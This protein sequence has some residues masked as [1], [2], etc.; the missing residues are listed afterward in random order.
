MSYPKNA[1]MSYSKNGWMNYPKNSLI[2]SQSVSPVRSHFV[3]T[4]SRLRSL[5]SV[6]VQRTAAPAPLQYWTLAALS[7][8]APFSAPKPAVSSAEKL[9]YSSDSLSS[10]TLDSRHRDGAKL[11]ATSLDSIHTGPPRS[12]QASGTAGCIHSRGLPRGYETVWSPPARSP[13][14]IEACRPPRRRSLGCSERALR[15]ACMQGSSLKD[16]PCLRDLLRESRFA[17]VDRSGWTGWI[18]ESRMER[19]GYYTDLYKR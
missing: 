13:R 18:K 12:L 6:P 1:W 15:V 5:L 8:P 16:S 2:R 10:L 17:W 14:Q 7:L 3:S 19:K 9:L 4:A 11:D